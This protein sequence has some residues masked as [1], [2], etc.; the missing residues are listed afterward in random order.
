MGL[1]HY[2]ETVIQPEVDKLAVLLE[3]DRPAR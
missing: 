3:R 2:F 1:L